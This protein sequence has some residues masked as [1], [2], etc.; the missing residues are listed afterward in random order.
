MWRRGWSYS[1]ISFFID[2]INAN[3]VY[4]DLQEMCYLPTWP[5]FTGGRG[6]MPPKSPPPPDRHH[7]HF[8]WSLLSNF[9]GV[10]D[11]VKPQPRCIQRIE[12]LTPVAY[13]VWI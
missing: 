9:D 6:E 5:F 4:D 11:S 10:D 8:D 1:R 2:D 13:N 12:Y 3:D 7:R